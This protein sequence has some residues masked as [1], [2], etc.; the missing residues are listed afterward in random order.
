MYMS[1]TSGTLSL[2]QA[3]DR[4]SIVPT[5]WRSPPE[6]HHIASRGDQTQQRQHVAIGLP[7]GKH[8]CDWVRHRKCLGPLQDGLMSTYHGNTTTSNSK[9]DGHGMPAA[10]RWHRGPA[11]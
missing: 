6:P 4:M 3:R 11:A 5:G 2:S 10:L 8:Q 1:P 7:E 9:V